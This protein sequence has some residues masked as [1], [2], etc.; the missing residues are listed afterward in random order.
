MKEPPVLSTG[1]PVCCKALFGVE[2]RW[3]LLGINKLPG[4][5]GQ[6]PLTPLFQAPGGGKG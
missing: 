6:A 2:G 3:L 4:I 5:K 1:D